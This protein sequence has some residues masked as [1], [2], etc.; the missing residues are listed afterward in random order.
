MLVSTPFAGIT[1][2]RIELSERV[3]WKSLF[4]PTT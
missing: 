2:Q 3:L 4:V 1:A